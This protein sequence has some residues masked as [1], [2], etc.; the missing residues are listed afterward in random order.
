MYDNWRLQRNDNAEAV[1]LP[2]DMRW[3]DEFAW[4]AVAQAE[5]Q[6]TLTGGLVIQQAV[7]HGG[8]PVTLAGD[9]VWLPR[10]TLET[11]R[12]WCDLPGLTMTLRH[13][14]GREYQVAFRLHDEVLGGVEPVCFA[15]PEA[16]AD[17]YTATIR[18]MTV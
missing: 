8:R 3:T 4:T 16:A 10:K 6:R 7:K 15:T 18:L 13:H 11:L 1:L 12:D 2:Q 17:R 5:P 9:W 14:D